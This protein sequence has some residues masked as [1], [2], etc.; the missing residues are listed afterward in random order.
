MPEI[1]QMLQPRHRS[2]LHMSQT[3][4]L[5]TQLPVSTIQGLALHNLTVLAKHVISYH[6]GAVLLSLELKEFSSGHVV[7]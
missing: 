2:N 1:Q 3:H 7:Q 4:A 6:V 5:N